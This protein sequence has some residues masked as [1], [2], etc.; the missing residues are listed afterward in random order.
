MKK[1]LCVYTCIT[2]NYDN[3]KEIV[4]IEKGIDYYCFTNNKNI[5]SNTWN[6]IY[7]EDKKLSNVELARKIKILGNSIVNKYDL[8]LWMDATVT[9]DKAIEEFI[10]DN[11]NIDDK[12]VAFKHGERKSIHEEALACLQ[13]NKENKKNIDKLLKF[14]DKEEYL[15]NNGLIESTVYIKRPKDKQVVETMNLWYELLSKYTTRDQLLFN[16]VIYKTKL[17]VHWIDENVFNNSWFTWHN[18]N[19]KKLGNYS[20]YFS[21]DTIN[22]KPELDYK[23]KY[24]I[25]ENNYEFNI[26][27]PIDTDTVIIEAAYKPFVK[28]NDI[29]IK[30]CD[31]SEITTINSIDYKNNR[32]FYTFPAY[33]IVRHNFKKN[34]KLNIS[35]KIEEM[36]D[37]E[38][39]E[40]TKYII[41]DKYKLLEKQLLSIYSSKG[42]KLLNFLRKFKPGK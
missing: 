1:K 17:K 35:F 34:S 19:Y 30:K 27:I 12:F 26:T 14:Y 33:I 36:N 10:K 29:K 4:N 39:Y 37:E 2:G 8:A 25:V 22:Y 41:D 42:W 24:N 3:L 11:M 16:Y 20:V 7:I 5:K 18:H 23:G 13:A 21:A 31:D 28:I 9:F 38:I 40:F 15:D 6:V 32:V